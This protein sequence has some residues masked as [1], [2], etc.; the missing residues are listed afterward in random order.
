MSN[1]E[2]RARPDSG[3]LAVQLRH[4]TPARPERT[5]RIVSRSEWTSC[6]AAASSTSHEVNASRGVLS[7][8]SRFIGLARVPW[9]R[10]Q[11]DTAKAQHPSN[12]KEGCE[13][14]KPDVRPRNVTECPP[15]TDRH[16]SVPTAGS[17]TG[18][19]SLLREPHGSPRSACPSMLDMRV[20]FDGYVAGTDPVV[21]EEQG[22]RS[23]TWPPSSGSAPCLGHRPDAMYELGVA[24]VAT[25]LRRT[26]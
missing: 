5:C 21:H 18:T 4:G 26:A 25:G 6:S 17:V 22:S 7:T 13:S 14:T 1:P 24:L 19:G 15:V 11:P 8:S 12:K 23:P 2:P 3:R 20:I 10:R 9:P 16:A